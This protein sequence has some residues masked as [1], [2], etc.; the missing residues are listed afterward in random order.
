[1]EC[2][3]FFMELYDRNSEEVLEG[4]CTI[5]LIMIFS[6]IAY[7]QEQNVSLFFLLEK[8]FRAIVVI[9][10][11][12]T[13]FMIGIFPDN[14][15]EYINLWIFFAFVGLLLIYVIGLF[16]YSKKKMAVLMHHMK[17]VQYI[18]YFEIF[19]LV[20]TDNLQIMEVVAGIMV[21]CLVECLKK[22]YVLSSRKKEEA[23][24]IS[25]SADD[26]PTALIYPSR[27][28]QLEKFCLVLEQVKAE[29]YAVMISGAWGVGKTSF[30]KALEKKLSKDTFVWIE[31]G[32][33]KLFLRSWAFF[34]GS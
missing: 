27:I 9:A 13:C 21:V 18:I 25:L 15:W 28:Q 12:W 22:I 8:I 34:L 24:E 7:L 14:Q 23:E 17:Y 31:S 5:L 6:L 4:A 26:C 16:I 2:I 30:V 29:P 11:G 1:M 32:S 10:I 20:G 3:R 19:L 33:E